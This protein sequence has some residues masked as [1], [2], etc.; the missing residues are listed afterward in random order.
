[1]YPE[2]DFQT[3]CFTFRA[4][5]L[6]G[7]EKSHPQRTCCDE[8]EC[9]SCSDWIYQ[10]QCGRIGEP[11]T[12]LRFPCPEAK[13][14]ILVTFDGLDEQV[15]QNTCC[16]ETAAMSGGTLGFIPLVDPSFAA[17]IW[18]I[19]GCLVKAVEAVSEQES[20]DPGVPISRDAE[21]VPLCMKWSRRPA[22]RWWPS[23]TRATSMCT[24]AL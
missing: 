15:R 18:K 1:M 12:R 13:A 4:G 20:V 3:G 10:A 22:C 2:A 17:D 5:S 16:V 21:V 14:Y 7:P 6:S 11:F 8:G 9:K 23:A 19:R 24:Y